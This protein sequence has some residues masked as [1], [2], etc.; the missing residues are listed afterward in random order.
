MSESP[1]NNQSTP[2]A[3]SAE[4]AVPVTPRPVPRPIPRPV[5]RPTPAVAAS[6]VPSPLTG[7]PEAALVAAAKAFGSVRED[8]TVSVRD[9]DSDRVVG[10]VPG[11]SEDEALS[12][13]I[14]RFLELRSKVQLFETRLATTEVSQHDATQT[15]SR[16]TE[17]L[18][19]P[20]A[21]G[22][23]PSLRL[24]LARLRDLAKEQAAAAEAARQQART[25][26]VAERTALVEQAEALATQDPA[27]I[28]WKTASEQLR[29]LLDGWRSAQ[30]NG[31]R[32]D[33]PTEDELWKRFSHARTT[34]DRER[35]HFFAELEQRH[36]EVKAAKER[37][38]AEAERLSTS[39]EWGATAGA[40]RD[41]MDQ[42]KAA[43]HASRKDDDALWARFRGAQ[44]SF[45]AA[46]EAV[47]S[48]IDAEYAANLVVKE[49]LLAEAEAL[50]PVT[51]LT[52]AKSRLR[53]IQDRWEAAGKVPRDAVQRVEARIRAVETAVRT[54]DEDRWRRSN[55]EVKAR[56]DGMAAQLESAIADL[57]ADLAQAEAAHND[58]KVKEITEGLSARRAWLDQIVK[59]SQDSAG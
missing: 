53:D 19:E 25:I 7:P 50:V 4:G 35:R 24:Q 21:V 43:G 45:F 2:S 18:S 51:D 48:A 5:P 27:K 59:A 42:W 14:R 49:A 52:V 26:A 39:S 8:G 56:A 12:L 13:Y 3:A 9:G 58:K 10:Q 47:N 16:L 55:P 30:K 15:L 37:L 23:L 44:D 22:D 6:S 11:V 57:E 40:Y 46:R 1:E 54:A 20:A 38:V 34:F 31:P 29:V 17:E 36:G 33:R 32:I 28:Q 41:L